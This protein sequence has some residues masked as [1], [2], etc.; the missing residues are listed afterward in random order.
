M[1]VVTDF[2]TPYGGYAVKDLVALGWSLLPVAFVMSLALN[3]KQA[4]PCFLRKD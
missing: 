1:N 3:K 4:A 2:G